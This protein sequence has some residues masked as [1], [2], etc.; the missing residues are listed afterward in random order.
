MMVVKR[1][2]TV[3]RPVHHRASIRLVALASALVAALAVGLVPFSSADTGGDK[4]KLD[5]GISRLRSQLED[6]SQ[7]LAKAFVDLQ[8]TKAQL[9]GAKQALAAADTAQ[10]VADRRNQ[11][12]A[13]ALAV[14]RANAA[15]AAGALAR[16]ARN[17]Q[18][19]QDQIVNMIRD[20][21]QRG[22][23]S[24]LSIALSADSPE[25]FTNR[26]IM[27]DTVMRVRLGTVRG[28][29]TLRAEG[30]AVGAHLV[31]VRQQVTI[32]KAQAQATLGRAQAARQI[33]AKA[34]AKV[35]H[36]YAV[37][38]RYAAMVSARKANESANLTKMQATSDALTRVL[39]A[40]ASADRAAAARA[41][42]QPRSAPPRNA[43]PRNA[44]PGNAPPGG[45]GGFLSYPVNAPVSSE[46]GMRYHPILHYW[47][48]HSGID[49]AADCGSPVYAAASGDVILSTVAG[50][51]GN[52]LVI[53][54][55]IQNGFD[56]T[57]TYNHLSS[58]V[59]TGGPVDRGQ[60]VAY[61]GTTGLS[62]GC[63]LHFE[64]R[65]DGVP[66]NPRLWF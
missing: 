36:L 34:K 42:H 38:T 60:L 18:Q 10:G 12:V 26:M 20:D 58:F 9:P 54:H 52:Q 16:N 29:D 4:K 44:R 15:R 22:G 19:S 13:V 5:S 59:V 49:F 32:L 35:D 37:Q 1:V 66:V 17:S 55:G 45:G 28:L 3:P 48:L 61:S 33:A 11:A 46:F 53:D 6:T 62:T 43:P 50:G 40:R 24:S 57:T 8:V 25:D 39:A 47:R 64:T 31:A 7:V 14:A 30:R 21:Y 23:V 27:M 65:E 56:L 41:T 63:H 2:L 51:Y